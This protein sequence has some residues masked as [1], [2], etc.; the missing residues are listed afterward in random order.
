MDED[1]SGIGIAPIVL[2][3]SAVRE[4]VVDTPSRASGHAGGVS[5]S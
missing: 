1:Q 2:N 4:K 5:G 3:L